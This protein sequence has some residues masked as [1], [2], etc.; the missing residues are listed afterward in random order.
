[1]S[2]SAA[3][4][5]ELTRSVPPPDQAAARSARARVDALATPPGALGRLADLAVA[6]AATTGV[7][8][9]AAP[10][11]PT[12]LIAAADHGV[13]RQGVTMWPQSVT[14]AIADAAVRGD[15]ASAVLAAGIG[16]ELVV[17]DV[18]IVE[19][20]VD[21]PRLLR[22]PV[23]PGT[24]DL[25][26]GPAMTFDQALAAVAAGADA[27]RNLIAGG[28]DLLALGDIGIANTTS[29]AALTAAFTGRSAAE[30]TGRG[31]G[32][33]DTT[34]ERK[35]NAVATALRRVGLETD[36]FV[37]LCQL[38]GLEHAALVGAMLSAT[39]NRV[40]V[41]LDGAITLSAALVAVALA[42]SL[43]DRLAS[44]GRTGRPDRPR[45]P[46]TRAHPR[47]AAPARRGLGSAAGRSDHSGCGR[48]VAAHRHARSARLKAAALSSCEAPPR[49]EKIVHR[50]TTCVNAFLQG[51]RHRFSCA[52]P[53]IASSAPKLAPRPRPQQSAQRTQ[54][55]AAMAAAYDEGTVPLR[56]APATNGVQLL[57]RCSAKPVSADRTD[58]GST[59]RCRRVAA[60]ASVIVSASM[61]R[62][63]V[64]R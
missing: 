47:P 42:P 62:R 19:P 39:A 10:A 12:L 43:P 49:P 20:T 58:L 28:T 48:R 23:A 61:L 59:P 64:S 15:A 22:A 9:P 14:A 51:G 25:T 26:T 40:P 1:M 24:A 54:T 32:A 41:V 53:R 30:A 21:H 16:A 18:G 35:R 6:L 50:S 44:P 60:S 13:H 38:G 37:S 29:T 17:L 11:R 63:P 31:A 5:A 46:G 52:R 34:L 4:L 57:W 33:D 36:P 3:D 7:C 55:T 56:P 2:F 45:P 8:P 27:A